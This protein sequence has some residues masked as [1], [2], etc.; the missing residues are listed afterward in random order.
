MSDPG[1]DLRATFA[2]KCRMLVKNCRVLVDEITAN[3]H[4]GKS[5]IAVGLLALITAFAVSMI[6]A[7]IVTTAPGGDIAPNILI[8]NVLEHYLGLFC[9]LSAFYLQLSDRLDLPYTVRSCPPWQAVAFF[10]LTGSSWTFSSFRL[11]TET[12][13]TAVPYADVGVIMMTF[14]VLASLVYVLSVYAPPEK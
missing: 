7:L 4:F 6:S 13:S 14:V 12:R 2:E 5:V 10:F 8:L 11:F 1:S 3:E 9:L